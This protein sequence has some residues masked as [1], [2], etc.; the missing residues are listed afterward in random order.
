MIELSENT[1]R[2]AKEIQEEAKRN[3][4]F[5]PRKVKNN[6]DISTILLAN[7]SLEESLEMAESAL[8][9]EEWIK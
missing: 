5:L 7:F 4:K 3:V 1:K 8:Q 2:L 9:D 6:E